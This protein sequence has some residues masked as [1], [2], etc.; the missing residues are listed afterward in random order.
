MEE[1]VI[2]GNGACHAGTGNVSVSNAPVTKTEKP[3]AT[4]SSSNDRSSLRRYRSQLQKLD[5]NIHK[6]EDRLKK[7]QD[8]LLELK[9][10]NLRI[11]DISK[12][13]SNEETQ[14]STEKKIREL[15]NNL[16]L[17]KKERSEVYDSGKRDGFLPGELEGRGI[18]P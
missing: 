15:Q 5:K 13:I 3:P 9:R 6:E 4:V 16:K 8:R 2:E 7:L 12:I 17:L 11:R 18:V 1:T 10:E 14:E